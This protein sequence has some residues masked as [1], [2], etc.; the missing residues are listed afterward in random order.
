MAAVART[1]IAIGLFPLLFVAAGPVFADSTHCSFRLAA[2][3]GLK[4]SLYP[5]T[6][7]FLKG[8]YK[9]SDSGYVDLPVIGC[10]NVIARPLSEIENDLNKRYIEYLNRPAIRLT[11]QIRVAVLGGF[12]NPGLFWVHP[13]DGIWDVVRIAGGPL[14]SDG[15]AKM[16]WIHNGVATDTLIAAAFRSG[17]PLTAM[18]FKSGDQ[19]VLTL[20]PERRRI[21][22][23]IEDALPIFGLVVTALSST[24]SLY[25]TYILY[26]QRR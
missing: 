17:E 26:D 4:I 8:V 14:R 21:D 6:A 12:R 18:G 10:I 23:F 19:L 3:D 11:P 7:H 13:F 16:Q 25:L 2:G 24:A 20:R 9:I 22:V 15:I 5:D 1:M